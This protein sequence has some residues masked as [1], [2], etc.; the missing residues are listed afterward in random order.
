MSSHSSG[1]DDQRSGD[2]APP[3]AAMQPPAGGRHARLRKDTHRQ[4]QRRY[5]ERQKV[6]PRFLSCWPL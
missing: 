1:S 2:P 4:A 6:G 5:R 3:Q